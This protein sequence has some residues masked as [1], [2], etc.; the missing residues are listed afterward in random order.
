MKTFEKKTKPALSPVRRRR[1][2][3][4]PSFDPAAQ[5]QRT[6]IRELLRPPRL[7]AKL[8]IGRPN[9][10]Y[11]QEADRV[12]EQV[13]SMPEPQVQCQPV[14]EEEEGK[15]QPKPLGKE[16][17]PLVQGQVAESEAKETP[18]YGE[19]E[20]PIWALPLTY[21]LYIDSNTGN[22]VDSSTLDFHTPREMGNYYT[23]AVKAR[24]FYKELVV[25][26]KGKLTQLE[27]IPKKMQEYRERG[28]PLPDEL[29]E[30]I[31]Q[32]GN[33][34]VTEAYWEIIQM[35]TEP[36]AGA[37][38]NLNPDSAGFC[39]IE[40]A[41]PENPFFGFPFWQHERVHQRDCL[42]FLEQT[43]SRYRALWVARNVAY[44]KFM[45]A[46]TFVESEIEAYK[47]TV[48]SM[49]K[50]LEIYEKK[51]FQGI[52][53]V[54]VPETYSIHRKQE[55]EKQKT[56]RSKEASNNN[57]EVSLDFESRIQSLKGSGQ[58]LPES[59]RAY[60]NPL[61]G[62][63]F[64]QVR[65]HKNS[66]T[67]EMARELNAKAF[68][69]GRNIVFGSGQ[70]SPET[71]AGKKLLAHELTHVVRQAN[72]SGHSDYNLAT[73]RF[74]GLVEQQS[75]RYVAKN[76]NLSK[77]INN[78][79]INGTA[80]I[81]QLQQTG[82]ESAS[83]TERSTQAATWSTDLLAL[84][85]SDDSL[86]CFGQAF[87]HVTYETDCSPIRPPF[88]QTARL[89]FDVH[90]FID[91]ADRPRPQPFTPPEVG[92]LFTFISTSGRR[93]NWINVTDTAAKYVA[94]NYP[95]EPKF[96]TKFPI[97]VTQ[98]GSLIIHLIMKDTTGINVIYNDTI[99]FIIEPCV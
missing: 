99:E 98:N 13:M 14:E 41:K 66:E 76:M 15:I 83:T 86:A 49:E 33:E 71:Q 1:T 16:F 24:D 56:S 23:E 30:L 85:I 39:K 81:L 42:T 7:Q 2:P 20:A 52:A 90:F 73:D 10:K 62:E 18:E 89:T 50:E 8:T 45:G 29:I 12:A 68:T 75:G 28:E 87:P 97:T 17:T 5:I 22:F 40:I 46:A 27:N 37:V 84:E 94:P 32:E 78:M 64:V 58:P 92:V 93:E 80:H 36:I 79:N 48:E 67:A 47:A 21:R 26:L 61:F 38:T 69:I 74:G 60:F 59:V 34:I 44:N 95:L 77:V 4:P 19:T 25:R 31:Q 88:C 11:E 96:G 57:P 6:Q 65:V 3:V 9:D 53:P 43:K 55:E 82:E 91:R 51:S 72:G 63:D 35:C 54:S 70:Y